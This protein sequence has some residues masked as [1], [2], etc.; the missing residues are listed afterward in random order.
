M[1]Y[2]TVLL[3]I[4]ATAPGNL[5][6]GIN[7]WTSHGPGGGNIGAM[8]IDPKSPGTL[9]AAASGQVFKSIGGG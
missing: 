3:T 4:L 8:A 7:V 1:R 2:A 9:Y 5:C 6:A